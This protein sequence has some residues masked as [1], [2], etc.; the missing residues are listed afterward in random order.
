MYSGHWLRRTNVFCYDVAHW[1]YHDQFFILYC[2][3]QNGIFSPNRCGGDS[4][5]FFLI[6]ELRWRKCSKLRRRKWYCFF[7]RENG[8]SLGK[9]LID[10]KNRPIRYSITDIRMYFSGKWWWKVLFNVIYHHHFYSL[11]TS[12]GS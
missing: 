5:Y 6:F 7:S 12:L 2:F 11:T 1:S 3:G 8:I 9:N 10:N 4:G